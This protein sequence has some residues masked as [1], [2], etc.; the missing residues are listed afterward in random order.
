MPDKTLQ[1]D[2]T[3]LYLAAPSFQRAGGE[4]SEAADTAQSTL[5]GMGAFWGNDAPGQTFGSTY[6]P[7]QDQLLQLI[8]ILAGSVS[9]VTDAINQMASNYGISEQANINK[10][11]AIEQEEMR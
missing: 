1:F 3:E 11:R 6:Q 5:M 2:L 4:V 8:A 7:A 9:G 10:M